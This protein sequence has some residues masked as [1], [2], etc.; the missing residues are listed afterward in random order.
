MARQAELWQ[1]LLE[2]LDGGLAVALLVVVDSRGS[3]P[4]K[5][6]AKMAV[7]ADD[8]FGTIGGGPTEYRL[9]D[10]ARTMLTA[11]DT[12]SKVF[13]LAHH[14]SASEQT[15]GAIC[16]GEQ[17][18][19]IYRCQPQDRAVFEHILK[20]DRDAAMLEWSLSAKGVTVTAVANAP[21]G[22][23]FVD[24]DRWSY[25]ERLGPRKQ[26]YI[27]G[28]GHVGLAL[29]KLLDWLDFEITVID[30]REPNDHRGVAR[31]AW[32]QWR[33]DYRQ[34]AGHVPEGSNVF[35]F[36]MT[37]SHHSDEQVVGQLAK[38][39]YAYLGLLGS[40][41]KIAHL[42]ARL[43]KTLSFEQLQRL[44]APMGLPIGSHTPEEIAVSIAAE[45]IQGLNLQAE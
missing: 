25:Q 45:L 6:G 29:A 5:A 28:A 38:K 22:S 37:S 4:G 14:A 1:W 36:I 10:L 33:L 34:L 17:T 8:C 44:H 13:H 35:V 41:H 40:N 20:A 32:R 21:T 24:G 15:S 30:V 19:A 42:Q 12:P 3:S 27:I 7:T 31:P 11:P 16:G 23:D 26:A 39:R 9:V 2:A 43:A 18:V